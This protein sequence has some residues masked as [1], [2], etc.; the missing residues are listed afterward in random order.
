MVELKEA[1]FYPDTSIWLDFFEKRGHER[2][3][4]K[5]FFK[6]MIVKESKIIFSEAIRDELIKYGFY[7]ENLNYLLSIFKNNLV[8][9]QFNKEQFGKANDLAIKRN[10]PRLD[11][12]HALL[13]RDN[14]AILVSRDR[15]FDKLLD[16][17]HYKKP[18]DI[19]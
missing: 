13:A 14:K 8:Y 19:I 18:E 7:Q 15:H 2:E 1:K 4:A 9:V 10:I 5:R 17:V 16:I 6:K 3:I 11:T 12:L